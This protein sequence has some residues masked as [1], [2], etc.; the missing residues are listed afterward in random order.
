MMKGIT[1]NEQGMMNIGLII[2]DKGIGGQQN[3]TNLRIYTT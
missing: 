1:N 3:L 2:I